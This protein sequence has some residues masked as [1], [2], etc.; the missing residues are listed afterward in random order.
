MKKNGT[1]ANQEG[2]HK[3]PH[4]FHHRTHPIILRQLLKWQHGRPAT[5]RV[6][7]YGPQYKIETRAAGP[8]KQHHTTWGGF[9]SSPARRGFGMHSLL[10][11]MP[12]ALRKV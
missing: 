5:R 6:C 12:A 1:P 10:V 3:R 9:L 7:W 8:F 2:Q 4:A 11:R